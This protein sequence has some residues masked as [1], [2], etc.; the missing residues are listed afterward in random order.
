MPRHSG[1][2]ERKG[3]FYLN[4]RV[5]KDLLPAYG[6]KQII[7][8]S[9]RTSDR[10]EAKIRVREEAFKLDSEFLEKRRALERA[11]QKTTPKRAVSSITDREAHDLVFRFFIELEKESEEFWAKGSD[12]LDSSDRE[13]VLEDLRFWTMIYSGGSKDYEGDDGSR[14]LDSLL[15]ESGMNCPK[16]SPAY[17]K[18]RSLVR[19]ARLENAERNI[20]RLNQV[21]VSPHEP[22]FRDVFAH[23]TPPQARASV[24][25]GETLI[26]FTKALTDAKRAERTHRTYEVPW[27][28]LR[29]RLGEST[30]LDAIRR[31]DIEALF[32]LLRRAPSNGSK[33]YP[34]RTLEEAI[35][36]ADKRG[37]VNRLGAKTLENY[38]NNIV[39]IFNF[40]VEK[41]LLAENPARD[42]WMRASF[43]ADRPEK[44]KPHFSVEELN[45][46][47]R[48]P[49]YCGCKD[50]GAG[51][52][53]PGSNRPRRGRFWVPLLALFQGLRCNE[54]AQLYTEDFKEEEGI[55]Y[56]EIREERED[57]SKCDKRLKTKQSKR[58]VP[59]HPEL[60]QIGF[61]EFVEKRR[62]DISHPRLF[63]E[64][65]IGATGYFSDRFGKWLGRF[66]KTTLGKE[67]KATFHSFRHKF[68]DSLTEAGIPLP[69]VEALGGWEIMQRSAERN[70]GKGP[71]LRRLREQI[72]KVAYPGLRLTHLYAENR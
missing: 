43:A 42:R 11:E 56:F 35:T 25:L 13:E 69:D 47:F 15:K 57:G 19:K 34:G 66:V 55:P 20:V 60:L 51:F 45:N 9:L 17:E 71:S 10:R 68:R 72:E 30:P 2:L 65:K 62:K 32:E 24:T 6:G 63:P 41:R 28:L 8:K 22:L 58:R 16:G 61:L 53:K 37:D 40:A 59:I 18:L 12:G 36:E 31:E 29:E 52:A 27:R 7:R 50:D 48:A 38:F 44:P 46:L 1:L 3:R 49:L 64:L 5:P 23:P 4:V 67:C 21:S 70:Y 14:D 33:R 26:R 39:A 54:A